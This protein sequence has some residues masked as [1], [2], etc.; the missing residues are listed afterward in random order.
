M[1]LQTLIPVITL[2][3]VVLGGLF[4]IIIAVVRGDMKKFIEQKMIEAEQTDLSGAKKLEYVLVA[5]KEK[6]KVMELFL[7]TKKFVEHVIEL[8][9]KINSK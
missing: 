1:E 2:G 5:V 3:V 7:N 4:S 8:S 6:Y 9:K